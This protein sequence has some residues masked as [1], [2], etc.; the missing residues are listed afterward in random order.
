M[1]KFALVL[2]A[3]LAATAGAAAMDL[4]EAFV[5][6]SNIPDVKEA[7]A[8]YNLPVEADVIRDGKLSAVYNL[9]AAQI[10]K[11]GDA[12]FTI[13]NLV[14]LTYM[15]NGGCNGEAAVFVYAAPATADTSNVLIAVMSGRRGALVFIY[16]TIDNTVRDIIQQA[17]LEMQG[18][19]VSLKADMPDGSN[20]NIGI[21]K[22]R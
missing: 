21:G 18:A 4:K 22:G 8:D 3:V 1:R 10:K 14:P 17:P 11:S 9:D 20:F 7:A 15:I 19:Y 12:A 2:L 6:L 16:G 13:L 5:A